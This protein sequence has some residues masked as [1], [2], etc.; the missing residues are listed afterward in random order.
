MAKTPASAL[1]LS[2]DS[3]K[4]IL[5]YIGGI[6]TAHRSLT[7]LHAKMEAIDVAYARYQASN[8]E[9]GESGLTSCNV[10][11]EDDV[12]A[13]IVVSQV[14]SMVA[15]LAE[16]FLSGY[17]LFPVVSTPAKRKWA[18]Q[19][20]TLLDDH[21]ILG[22]YA[23]QLLIF[24]RD[25]VKYNFC[26]IETDWTQI[27]QFSVTS[28]F[29]TDIGRQL[30]R[31]A[32]YY[33][34]VKRLDPY[35]TIYDPTVLPGDVAREGDYAGYIEVKS[36][37]KLKRL[38]NKLAKDQEAYNA[39]EALQSSRGM[40]PAGT[41]LNYH[42]HPTVSDYITPRRPEDRVDWEKYITGKATS[43]RMTAADNYEHVVIYGRII[44]SELGIQGPQPNTPQ[45]WKFQTINNIL[46]SAKRI[47]SAFDY[48]PILLGQPLEDGL[49]YQTQSVAESEIP[50]QEAATTLY[51]IRFAAARRAVSDR[52]L[53]DPEMIRPGDINAAIPAPKIPVKCNPLLQKGIESAYRQ[54][55]FDMRGTETTI[56]DASV[57]VDFSKQLHGLNNA[58]QGQFQKG[59][60]SVTEFSTIMGGSDSRLRM[61][62]LTLEHQIFIPL[63][64][65]LTLNIF[66][67]GADTIVVSQKTGE[68]LDIKIDE[69]RKQVLSF[70][71][72][73]GYTPKS[74]LASTEMITQGLTVIMNSPALQQAYGTSLPSLFAHMM[75]LGGVRGLEEYAPE[76]QAQAVASP[77]PG[78]LEEAGLQNPAGPVAPQSSQSSQPPI[79]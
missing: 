76:H 69:L 12:V 45:I 51:N 65:I 53:Y 3:Q 60:K 37:T 21:A 57:L 5:S 56:Q 29:T 1:R 64:S 67:Y 39:T 62:A 61:P 9:D 8:C 14:D 44:P 32:K 16:I 24:L 13:P 68:V 42:I 34:A 63:K 77:M 25:G 20:E 35:N 18:E 10:F 70:R 66:Q 74:K 78:G 33:T 26:G 30:K 72:A 43:A 28:D 73:D 17:P 71:V 15:Y 50:I 49:G 31:D 22:G 11:A 48:L 7:E 2:K 79:I 59:N 54:V 38:L 6:L 27:E 36:H 19:L 4:A 23:R 46:I 58:Q 41:S 47:V 40:L 75:Q 52:A 55:P